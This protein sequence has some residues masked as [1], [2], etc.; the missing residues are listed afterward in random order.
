MLASRGVRRYV[1]NVWRHRSFSRVLA[2]KEAGVETIAF[3]RERVGLSYTLNWALSAKAI[4]PSG[5]VY[6]NLKDSELQDHGA[7]PQD[8]ISGSKIFARGS[9]STGASEI[10]KAQFN[11]L[12]KEVAQHL[13]SCSKLFVQDG[14]IGASSKHV[15]VRAVCDNPSAAGILKDT[16]CSTVERGESALSIYV[17]SAHKT[18]ALELPENTP[19]IAADYDRSALIVGGKAFADEKALKDAI[20]ALAAPA[21]VASGALPLTARV[22]HIKDSHVIVAGPDSILSK[23]EAVIKA[24]VFPEEGVLWNASFGATRFFNTQKAA[25]PKLVSPAALVLVTVDSSGVLPEI[26]K[27]S[28]QQCAF[29]SLAGYDGKT[30]TPAYNKRLASVDPATLAT[31]LAAML[32]RTNLPALLVNA[33][34]GKNVPKLIE[35]AATVKEPKSNDEAVKQWSDRHKEFVA[36][37]FPA[38]ALPS[39]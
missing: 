5:D 6:D 2:M 7:R 13:S 11:K 21:I 3:P 35:R 18:K 9:Y 31:E 36:R 1:W 10:S 29:L 17:A 33:T 28:P 19:F 22:L 14:S 39:I 34:S 26:T 25:V 15:K 12:F 23:N 20:A 4:P 30:Y 8:S 32:T 16:L 37:S 24:S 38:F 27:L